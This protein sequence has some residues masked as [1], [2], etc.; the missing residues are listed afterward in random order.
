M[1]VTALALHSLLLGGSS[2]AYT[3]SYTKVIVA[4]QISMSSLYSIWKIT[5][6]MLQ[7]YLIS[8]CMVPGATLMWSMAHCLQK[9]SY[10]VTDC[11]D[12][13]CQCTN[14]GYM[15]VSFKLCLVTSQA[16]FS[17]MWIR[18][19]RP[20]SPKW[21][22]GMICKTSPHLLTLNVLQARSSVPLLV[23]VFQQS[24]ILD[25][26]IGGG[27]LSEAFEQVSWS[28]IWCKL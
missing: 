9:Q 8:Y 6:Q 18:R 13:P 1:N 27:D 11:F 24:L 3:H 25:L 16:L 10:C 26:A 4:T 22:G 23:I 12:F 19:M 21:R 5:Y 17:P 15:L 14:T 7:T 28:R 20:F 2:Y